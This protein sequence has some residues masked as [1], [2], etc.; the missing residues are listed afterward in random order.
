M[1]QYNSGNYTEALQYGL[2]GLNNAISAKD[3]SLLIVHYSNLANIYLDLKQPEKAQKYLER[4]LLEAQ[5]INYN[6]YS[7]YTLTNINRLLLKLGR[8]EE[9]LKL[10]ETNYDNIPEEKQRVKM[11]FL[12]VLT[13]CYLTVKKYPKAEESI[14]RLLIYNQTRPDEDIYKMAVYDRA[15]ALYLETK[16]Y[17]KA[18]AYIKESM[19]LNLAHKSLNAA[20][21]HQLLLFRID[22]AQGN[23]GQAITHYQHYKTL[24]DS[25]YS[26]KNGQRIAILQI[27]HETKEKEQSIALLTKRNEVQQANLEKKDIQQQL[28]IALALMLLL[29]LGISY[30]RYR[31]KQRS[32]QLLEA[33]QQE[34]NL[35]NTSLQQVLV[36]KEEILLHKD[37]LLEEKEW[38]LKE[39]HH[40]VKN[41]LQIVM[42]LLNTQA[43]YLK[44]SKAL[45][46]IQESQ[47]R[48]HAIS[49][50]HQKLYQ[51]EKVALIHM[52]SYIREV[53]DYLKE[54]FS[55]HDRIRFDLAIAPLQLDVALAV[56]LGLIINEAVTNCLK[57]AFPQG[58]EGVVTISLG[59]VD[60]DT[61]LLIIEDDGIGLG[62]D[63]DI[64]R[65]R[66]LGMNII[67]GLSKQLKAGLQVE[68]SGGLKISV[69]FNNAIV[70]KSFA[71]QPLPG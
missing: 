8:A 70:V 24:S 47:Q 63:F 49:L 60:Q 26:E 40:R 39:I 34:I 21:H 36:E 48:V 53:V 11:M 10:I 35:K 54:Y 51:S 5:R 14:N 67:K 29:M 2:A 23:L 27:G 62:A 44:D 31:L 41:N 15:G 9:A 46:A 3:S 42:S 68:G 37:A 59:P 18:R 12:I 38:L 17:K 43:A 50:I 30:N 45:S 1:A 22:S 69:W 55:N 64:S 13:D 58:G 57:Y 25:I 20:M 19:S 4:V 52:D 56:P 61:Y 65:T 71:D 16:Q 33:K 66:T 28:F 32:T 6:Y 7:F